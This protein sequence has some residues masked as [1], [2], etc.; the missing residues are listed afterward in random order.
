MSSMQQQVAVSSETVK[1][2]RVAEV[3]PEEDLL[4]GIFQIIQT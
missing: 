1:T 2:N 4:V 3:T